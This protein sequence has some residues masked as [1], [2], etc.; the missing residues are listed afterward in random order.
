MRKVGWAVSQACSSS[1]S[2][3]AW[4]GATQ[5]AKHSRR[6][7]S[8]RGITQPRDGVGSFAECSLY[9]AVPAPEKQ[10]PRSVPGVLVVLL[11]LFVEERTQV[12][13]AG[14]MTQ[15]AQRL[16]FDLPDPL[17]G[18][19]EL[20][21][22]FLEG[23][24]GVH[25]DAEAHAQYLGFTGS[26]AGQYFAGRFLEA[27]YRGDID[28]RLHGG[29]FDEVT[30]MGVFVVAD[31]GFHGDRLFGDLQYLAD[32]VLRHFHAL[33]QFFRSRLAAPFLKHLTPNTV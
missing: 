33:A 25:V 31:R 12:F 24:V 23:V 5:K 19:I 17:A 13:T 3:K 32:F 1:V 28:G 11:R 4:L 9:G 15:L 22:D 6:V 14:R 27:F 20:L 26:E 10:N 29:V 8:S 30:Q 7:A 2:V 16:G 18:Y 21:T